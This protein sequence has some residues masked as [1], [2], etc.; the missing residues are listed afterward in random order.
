MKLG[1]ARKIRYV[2][3][4]DFVYELQA[5]RQDALATLS[6]NEVTLEKLKTKLSHL[7]KY[8]PDRLNTLQTQAESALD[9]A[10]R[11]TGNASLMCL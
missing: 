4:Y 8:H 3:D 9:S 7:H 5:E 10:N 6:K 11:W 1:R 2:L